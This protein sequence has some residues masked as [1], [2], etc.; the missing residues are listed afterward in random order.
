M[1]FD[2]I[3]KSITALLKSVTFAKDYNLV[4][5]A[6][7]FKWLLHGHTGH[8]F[9][10][11][12]LHIGGNIIEQIQEWPYL[13]HIISNECNDASDILNRK[14]YLCRQINNVICYFSNRNSVVKQLLMHA[15]CSSLYDCEL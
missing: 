3:L 9:S 4:F 11:L 7:K 8:S 2:S 14:H 5:N 6:H 10:K 15:Y 12:D 1:I 13:E